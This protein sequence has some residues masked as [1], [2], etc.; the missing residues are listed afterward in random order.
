MKQ[1]ILVVFV[2]VGLL[3]LTITSL[4]YSNSY[5]VWK[6]HRITEQTGLAE[7]AAKVIHKEIRGYSVRM[8]HDKTSFSITIK[9]GAVSTAMIY[10][11]PPELRYR[12]LKREGTDPVRITAEN[13]INKTFTREQDALIADANQ[14][15]REISYYFEE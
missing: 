10:T 8:V 4:N 14:Q 1:K 7:S 2:W 6:L 5:V 3:I 11:S 12:E 13:F 9:N 15:L